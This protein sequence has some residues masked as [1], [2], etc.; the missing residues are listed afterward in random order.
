MTPPGLIDDFEGYTDDASLSAGKWINAPNNYGAI[1][2]GGPPFV[3]DGSRSLRFDYKIENIAGDPPTDY[4]GVEIKTSGDWSEYHYF[5]VWIRSDR[6]NKDLVV[7]FKEA[8]GEPWL[9]RISLSAITEEVLE[10]PFSA[11]EP[12]DWHEGGDNHLDLRSI[13]NY[14][15]YVGNGGKGEDTVFIDSVMVTRMKG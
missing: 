11:F 13:T 9:Y 5:S 12:V 14:S 4:V 8:S 15:F 3:H 1:S 7:Q 10:I 6:S 2:L